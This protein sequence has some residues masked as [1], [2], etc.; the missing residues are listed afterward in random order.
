MRT[1]ADEIE[2]GGVCRDNIIFIDL[3]KRGYRSVRTADKLEQLISSFDRD[4]MKY[5]FIDEVQNVENFEEVINSFRTEGGW[6]IFITGSNSYL[7]SG[8]LVTKLTGRY[9]EFEIFPLSFQEYEQMKT[10]YKKHISV[11]PMEEFTAYIFEGGF[12]R[13][14]LFDDVADKRLYTQSVVKE[15]F[16]KDIRKRLKIRGAETFEKVRRYIINNFGC[17][18]SVNNIVDGLKK[19]GTNITKQTVSRYINA[20]VDAKILYECPR[21]DMKSKTSLN[22]E[23]KYYI[24][25]LSFY[26]ADNVDNRINYGPVLEN[27]IYT[28]SKSL[29]YAVSVGRIGKFEC[30]FILRSKTSDYSYVQVAYTIAGSSETEERE[31]RPLEMVK[32]NYPKYLLTTD[33]IL[34]KRNGIIHLNIIDFIANGKQF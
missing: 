15:I 6:S 34:Q 25:D 22:G 31:F 27:I 26:F 1:V 5:L 17:T 33:Y 2:G 7:L 18:T 4:G 28:Y 24:S 3:D 29:D 9:V 14:V 16:E 32:D 19:N 13:A 12:P 23:K 10:F 20:L 8:E 30:D 11:N 21:F